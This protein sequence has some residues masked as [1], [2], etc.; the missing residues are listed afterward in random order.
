M[1]VICGGCGNNCCNGSEG[2]EHCASAYDLIKDYEK[3][4]KLPNTTI[5]QTFPLKK[6]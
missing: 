4:N 1:T 6:S 5:G 3:V 2:C